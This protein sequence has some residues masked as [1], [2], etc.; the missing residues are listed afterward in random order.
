MN[1]KKIAAFLTAAALLLQV[2]AFAAK[3]TSTPAEAEY[4]G[5]Y[6][7]FD[8]ISDYI[9][10][11][12]IDD[13]SKSEIMAKGLS[14]Y[15]DGNDP[16]LVELLKATLESLD[17]YSEFYTEEEYKEYIEDL[18]HIYYGI[19]VVMRRQ[20]DGTVGIVDFAEGSDNAQ[21]AGFKIGDVFSKINGEDVTGMGVD[22]IRERVVGE[23]GTTVDITVLRDG[24]EIELNAERVAVNGFSVN[25]YMLRDNI[26]YI[27]II[28]FSTETAAEF[29]KA[30]QYMRDNN[31]K[32]IILDLRNNG[33]GLISSA[34]DV[35][36][37]I[38]PKGK[39]ADLKCRDSRYDATYSSTLNKKEF[40]FAVLVNEGTASASELLAGA[41]Q[42]SKAGTLIGTTTYGKAVF[43]NSFSLKNGAVF[44]LTVGE[45]LTRN[46]RKINK[47]GLT[48][49]LVVENEITK[50][51]TSKMKQFNF[52]PSSL[53][54]RCDNARAAKERLNY[55]GFFGGEINDVYDYDLFEAI[56]AFQ[57]ANNIFSYGVLD[58]TTQRRI[59]EAS[60]DLDVMND[61]QIDAAFVQLGG[62][63]AE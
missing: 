52:T 1:M 56:K 58:A 44:K 30:L 51:D 63:L 48:P 38:V 60:A 47:I 46:G 17:D 53:G 61:H 20:E 59:D 50:L 34:V 40:D 24:K 19:G 62:K 21:K 28:S 8:Q 33:G 37:A 42:D 5:E 22:E 25:Y 4:S 2:N 43:Q 39:I 26:G 16:V 32:K 6:Q 35:A 3:Q 13:Y 9:S 29:E 57:S 11:L 12:Y 18:N 54:E 23:E 49:D 15:L 14:K 10:E 55:L 41:L 45:Y 31:A 27:R 7:A 36:K